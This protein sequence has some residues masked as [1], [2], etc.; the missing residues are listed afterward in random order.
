M[1][2][3]GFI[4]LSKKL[5]TTRQT[6]SNWYKKIKNR[7]FKVKKMPTPINIYSDEFNQNII[8][9]YIKEVKE[10]K[11]R[12]G[13]DIHRPTIEDFIINNNIIC[14]KEH[15]RKV[16]IRAGIVTA[17]TKRK[18]KKEIKKRL[19]KSKKETEND[20]ELNQ[21]IENLKILMKNKPLTIKKGVPGFLVEIVGCCDL[22]EIIRNK[23]FT[24][25]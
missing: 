1:W 25:L 16:L 19:K 20:K 8:D 7:M 21:I 5:G 10:L 2:K 4:G 23:P 14:S 17:R 11:N 18:T 6:A 15:V 9:L 24:L 13:K 12:L 3:D 22:W